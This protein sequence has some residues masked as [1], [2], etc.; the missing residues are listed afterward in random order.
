M[1][2]VAFSVKWVRQV[3]G[4]CQIT[5]T[6]GRFGIVTAKLSSAE[7]NYLESLEMIIQL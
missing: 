1:S 3:G 4:T 2:E 7:V 6:F 5:V